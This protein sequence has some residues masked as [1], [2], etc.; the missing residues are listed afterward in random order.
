ALEELARQVDI[1]AADVRAGEG[2]VVE[3]P[4]APGKVDDHPREGLIEGHVSM[5]VPAHAGLVAHGGR[6]GLAQRD[7][8]VFHGVMV[9]DVDVAIAVDV[10]VDQAVAGD[11]VEHVVQEGNPGVDALAARAIEID[12]CSHAGFLGIA[13]NVGGT[14]VRLECR[15]VL[16]GTRHWLH[17]PAAPRRG[18]GWRQCV[19][20]SERRPATLRSGWRA[21]GSRIRPGARRTAPCGRSAERGWGRRSNRPAIP[22]Y[23]APGKWPRRGGCGPPSARDWRWRFQGARAQSGWRSRRLPRGRGL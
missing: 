7:A 10:E 15:W 4:G 13:G 20:V 16:N 8:D 12:G 21:S 5:A 19:R 2:H 18:Q 9:V 22:R 1:E 17:A 14:H 6:K 23:R 11:L 3:E